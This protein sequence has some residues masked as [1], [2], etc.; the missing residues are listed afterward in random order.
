[1]SRS[2]LGDNCVCM[3][4]SIG[5]VGPNSCFRPYWDNFSLCIFCYSG[6]AAETILAP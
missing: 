3:A 6:F 2:V 5:P 4:C 1:M